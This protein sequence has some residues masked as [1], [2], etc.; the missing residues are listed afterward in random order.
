MSAVTHVALQVI[1]IIANPQDSHE[2][3]PRALVLLRL[4]RLVRVVDIINVSLASLKHLQA[5][6]DALHCVSYFRGVVP[7]AS[8]KLIWKCRGAG[9]CIS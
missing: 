7:S 6:M 5:V 3:N 1:W 2:M 4:L 9:R 8:P